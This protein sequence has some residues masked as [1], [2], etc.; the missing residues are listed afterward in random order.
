MIS[1]IGLGSDFGATVPTIYDVEI[2]PK[3]LELWFTM[4]PKCWNVFSAAATR[5]DG[6]AEL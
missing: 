1:A 5:K 2:L 4:I 6:S 3:H